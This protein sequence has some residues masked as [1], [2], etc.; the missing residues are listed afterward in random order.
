MIEDGPRLVVLDPA[1]VAVVR[2]RVAPDALRE[3]FDSSFAALAEQ[4]RAQGVRPVAAAHALYRDLAADAWDLEVGFAVDRP[5]RAAGGVEPG[6][7]PGGR[8]ATCVH[9]GGYDGL[10]ASW[11]RLRAWVDER[12]LPAGPVFWE[13]YLTE[14]GPDVDPAVLRTQLVQPVVG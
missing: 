11:E 5:V 4:L 7:L 9:T 13:V 14:P 8:A 6:A 2:A 12:G 10:G 1:A 3:F